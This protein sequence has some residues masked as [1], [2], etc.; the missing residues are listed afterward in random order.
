MLPQPPPRHSAHPSARRLP[1]APR[2]PCTPPPWCAAELIHG[3]A[4]AVHPDG[5]HGGQAAP[6]GAPRRAVLSRRCAALRPAAQPHTWACSAR[7]P[8]SNRPRSNRP[9]PRAARC[10]GR[11]QAGRQRHGPH[12]GHQVCAGHRPHRRQ[13]APPPARLCSAAAGV[14]PPLGTCTTPAPMGP[15]LWAPTPPPLPLP[16]PWQEEI[17]VDIVEKLT[18]IFDAQGHQKSSSIVGAIQARGAGAPAACRGGAC[19]IEACAST[20]AAPSWPSSHPSATP[21]L[22]AAAAAHRSRAT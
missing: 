4:E 3:A 11:R 13:G 6:G 1:R 8:Q 2:L 20:L 18:A 17:F 21:Q 7:W 9:P 14:P 16:R 15:L 19:P 22:P 12:R 5:A 10:A